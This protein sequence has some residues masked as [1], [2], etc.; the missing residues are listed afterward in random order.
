MKC[1]FARIA[2]LCWVSLCVESAVSQDQSPARAQG[3]LMDEHLMEATQDMRDALRA[4][5]DENLIKQYYSTMQSMSGSV[6]SYDVLHYQL[7]ITFDIPDPS[8][9]GI[10]RIHCQSNEADLS[11][12]SLHLVDLTVDEVRRDGMIVDFTHADGCLEIDLNGSFSTGEEF[13]TQVRYHGTPTTGYR[14]RDDIFYTSVEPSRARYWWPCYDEPWDKA[15]ADINATVPAE[16]I[17]ASNGV[18]TET[19]ED[20]INNM[21][22]FKWSESYPIATYLVSVAIAQYV[23]YTDTYYPISGGDPM[24]VIFY[25]TPSLLEAAQV[26]FSQTVE[27]MEVYSTL[28]GEYPFLDEKYGTAL[29]PMAGAMEHQTCTTYSLGMIDGVYEKEWVVAHELAHQW[30]GDMVTMLD[31]RHIWLNEGFA[32]YAEALWAEHVGGEEYLHYFV[33]SSLQGCIKAWLA[34]F[35]ESRHPIFDPPPGHLFSPVTYEKAACVLHMLRFLAGSDLFFESLRTYGQRYM[36]G[37]ATTDELKE[38]FEDVT[39]QDLDW[40]FEQWIYSPGYPEYQ[41]MWEADGIEGDQYEVTVYVNQIQSDAPIFT[42]PVEFTI[43]TDEG[44]ITDTVVVDQAYQTIQFTV[45]GTPSDVLLDRDNWI[46]KEVTDITTPSVSPEAYSI[47][48]GAGNNNGIP[49]AGETVD[50]TVTLLNTGTEATGLAA[51]ISTEDPDVEIMIG[52]AEFGDAAYGQTVANDDDP[53]VFRVTGEVNSHMARFVM[54]ITGDG[55]YSR[56]D[57]L[58]IAIGPAAILVVDDDNGESYETYYTDG[59]LFSYPFDLWELAT[60]GCPAETLS[61]YETVVWFTGD[62]RTTTLTSEEQEALRQYLDGGGN[63]FISGQ[64]IGYDLVEDGSLDDQA[65]YNNYL[66]AI[67]AGDVSTETTISGVSNDPIS[68]DFETL[69]LERG[70]ARNQ[71]SPSI[72]E[73]L[74][75]TN[76]VFTYGSTGHTAGI[77]YSGDFKIVYFAFGYEGLGDSDGTGHAKKRA[78]IMDGIAEWFRYVP[79]KGDINEDGTVNVLDVILG[80]NIILDIMDPSPAQSWSADYNDDSIVNILDI[81]AIVNVILGTPVY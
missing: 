47:D 73:P 14:N 6:H 13:E 60:R 28:F 77:K 34:S 33:R 50:L 39:G 11:C 75:G 23:T 66:R 35:P 32:T 10:V 44:E 43:M 15:T 17:V 1:L 45:E 69:S 63:L 80:I 81:I 18:L 40:F 71:H 8:L 68:G 41:Y 65:F 51:S 79:C 4:G 7:D 21:I 5:K 3:N 30:W 31:W 57:S 54:D 9:S 19:M 58:F 37:N 78:T 42:M 61:T 67:Y 56:S 59:L 26:D 16:Y 36:Y 46:L 64:D 62:D 2:I 38:V 53:F 72:I 12:I 70:G 52:S 74:P 76:T 48:D 29:A 24:D 20:S 27:M 25:V 55:G 49:D 22:T